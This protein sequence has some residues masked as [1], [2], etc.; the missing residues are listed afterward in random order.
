MFS[1]PTSIAIGVF[2][3]FALSVPLQAPSA[4]ALTTSALTMNV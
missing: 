2:V 4:A 3:A 1:G